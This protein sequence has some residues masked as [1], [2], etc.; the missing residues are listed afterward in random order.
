MSYPQDPP[1]QAPP[2]T[3]IAAPGTGSLG[4]QM[5]LLF[6]P[7]IVLL[8]IEF[9]FGIIA[10]ACGAQGSTSH[11]G[12]FLFVAIVAWLTAMG[13]FVVFFFNVAEAKPIVPWLMIYLFYNIAVVILYVI[14]FIVILALAGSNDAYIAAGVSFVFHLFVF[15]I[16][17]TVNFRLT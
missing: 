12:W 8:I 17:L 1:R 2:P 7:S 5:H 10:I 16:T 4:P 9:I 13:W 6:T 15:F 3:V 11:G 14:A